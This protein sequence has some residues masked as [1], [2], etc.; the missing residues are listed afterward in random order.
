MAEGFF[1]PTQLP[2]PQLDTQRLIGAMVRILP[3]TLLVLDIAASPEAA[4]ALAR[5]E[6]LPDGTECWYRFFTQ[7]DVARVDEP[8]FAMGMVR[9]EFC[10][11]VK[12]GARFPAQTWLDGGGSG[13]C[14][15]AQGHVLT[16]YHLVSGEVA[17]HSRE[18]GVIGAEV[19]CKGLRAEIAQQDESGHWHWVPASQVYLVSN[20]SLQHA[21]WDDGQGRHHLRE[22]TAVLRIEPA[23]QHCL[24][25]SARTAQ[26]GEP[27]WMAGFPLRSARSASAKA[28]LGYS[29][30]DGSLRVSHGAVSSVDG[31]TYFETDLDGSMGNSGSPV[32]DA[33]GQVIGL[34]SR[35]S[36]N[37]PKNA[38]E[39]GHMARVHVSTELAT[40]GLQIALPA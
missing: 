34:F 19:P 29:D 38:F 33:Q 32:F 8:E 16:N 20:P 6:S 18:A 35:A 36:G 11:L 39:Y 12:A 40:R 26:Q 7:E 15:D 21:L 31:S 4:Q 3:K 22:D 37:G 10:R 17:T 14:F 9:H 23:P 24:P 5:N 25:L 27:V 1:H 28:A 30:A 2:I 13:F